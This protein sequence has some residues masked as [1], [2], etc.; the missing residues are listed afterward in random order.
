[1]ATD[2]AGERHAR[3]RIRL[4]AR[5]GEPLAVPQD[6]GGKCLKPGPAEAKIVRAGARE[7]IRIAG[8]QI[9]PVRIQ[10]KPHVPHR[11]GLRRP[12]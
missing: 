11:L 4:D 1:M 7:Q 2:Q 3:W 6:R 8:G 5:D 12:S 9:V 10:P